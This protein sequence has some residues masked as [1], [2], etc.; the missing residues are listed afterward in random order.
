[1]PIAAID[2]CTCADCCSGPGGNAIEAADAAADGITTR[3]WTGARCRA[4]PAFSS[5]FDG[6]F[7]RAAA[8]APAQ[9]VADTAADASQPRPGPVQLEAAAA[10]SA[11][12]NA[13][14]D[15]VAAVVAL[16]KP[17]GRLA[18]GFCNVAFRT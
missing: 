17:L 10:R 11:A 9:R 2:C 15:V 7:G 12:G 5:A 16:G 18:L 8:V 6:G 13:R 4:A 14:A 3:D 1:M